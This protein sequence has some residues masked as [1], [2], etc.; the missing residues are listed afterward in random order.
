MMKKQRNTP[1]DASIT[2]VIYV[3][4]HDR[5]TL[6]KKNACVRYMGCLGC[7]GCFEMVLSR[8]C[9]GNLECESLVLL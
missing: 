1:S 5:R 4:W 8:R 7:L 2:F 6:F 9:L 3:C